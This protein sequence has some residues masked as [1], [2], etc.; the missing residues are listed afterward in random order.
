[1]ALSSA[2]QE[3]LWLRSLLKGLGFATLIHEDNQGTIELT[4]NSKS[5]SRT[6]HIDIRYHFVKECIQSKEI[7]LAYCHTS[8]MI[9]DVFTKPLPT[10][11]FTNL[12]LDL[13]MTTIPVTSSEVR[14]SDSK[15]A[16]PDNATPSGERQS[17]GGIL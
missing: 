7:V 6:K 2:T 10:S 15:F 16:T 3:A 1:M 4:K 14:G 17:E 12:V 13:G 8:K 11:Q 9:A 5:H